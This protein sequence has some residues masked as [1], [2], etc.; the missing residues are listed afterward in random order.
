[1]PQGLVPEW[2]RLEQ[3]LSKPSERRPK[4]RKGYEALDAKLANEPDEMKLGTAPP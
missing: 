1:M 4:S 3:T 2:F